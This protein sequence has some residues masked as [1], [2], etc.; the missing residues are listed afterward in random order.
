MPEWL[1]PL[2]GAPLVAWH[3]SYQHEAIHGH[4]TRIGWLNA[5]LAGLP[6]ML[7]VPYGIYRDSHLKHHENEFLTDPIEDPES[8]Y[9]S[10]GQWALYSTPRRLLHR[11]VN[12]LAGRLVIG[13]LFVGALFLCREAMAFLRGRGRWKAWGLHVAGVAVLLVWLLL[14]CGMPLWTY[15]L[16]FA[17]P[18]TGLLLLRSFAEHH[19]AREPEGR[20][21]IVEAEK[22]FALLFLNNNL[23]VAH[24]TRPG[25][26]WYRLPEYEVVRR[27]GASTAGERVYRGYREIARR[28]LFRV[29]E[30]PVH[31]YR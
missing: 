20:T 16:C 26:P 18:G 10:R 4:P 2:A 25:M 28:W 15:I 24:H 1:L 13:P 17:Y 14:V 23:H 11:A 27:L 29:K 21:A 7:W 31:P 19:A 6:L 3:A 5:T 9:A 8:F 12:T 30:S 22:P